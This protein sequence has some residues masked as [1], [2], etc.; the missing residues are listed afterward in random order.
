MNILLMEVFEMA[1][2]NAFLIAAA[3]FLLI[4]FLTGLSRGLSRSVLRL[5]FVV[6]IAVLSFHLAGVAA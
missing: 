5:V 2:S 1:I 4:G 6:A 3:V